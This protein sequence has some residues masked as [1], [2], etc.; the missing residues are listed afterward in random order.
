MKAGLIIRGGSRDG[1]RVALTPSGRITF[2]RSPTCDERFEDDSF[3][4]VHFAIEG[5]GSF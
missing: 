4:R 5:K 1:Q 2:G 3:S